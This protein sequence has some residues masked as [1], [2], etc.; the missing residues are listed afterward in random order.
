MPMSEERMYLA[1]L[2][3]KEKHGS[4]GYPIPLAELVP[5]YRNIILDSFVV[6]CPK[7]KGKS[8]YKR[9]DLRE[10]AL[11]LPEDWKPQ[12]IFRKS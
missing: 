3:R 5:D 12:P 6:E 10:L 11:T 7:C 2:C 8:E 4:G 9:S 1:V